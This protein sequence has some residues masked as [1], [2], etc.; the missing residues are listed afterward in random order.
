[1]EKI[2]TKSGLNKRQWALYRYLKDK[3]DQWTTQY[4]I[5]NDLR[6]LYGY[7]ED[8]FVTFHDSQAR[9]Q[10]TNDI[11]TINE[12]D[13]IIKPILSSPRGIKLASKTEFDAYIGRNINSVINRLKRL[14]KLAEKG[15]KNGQFRIK[16][17]PYQ[18]ELYESFIDSD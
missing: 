5:V 3:G 6:E 13:Y 2:E 11:R 4:N 7:K 12:S 9:H 8:D 17:S 15:S 10:L 1:M 16:L 14:K 18:K